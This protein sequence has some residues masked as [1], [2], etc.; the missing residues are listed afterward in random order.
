MSKNIAV[1]MGGFSSEYGI[2]LKSGAVVEKHLDKS[3]FKTFPIVVTSD[4][5]YFQDSSGIQYEV[6]KAD[7]SL[8][9]PE[10]KVVFDCV[11]NAIHGTPRSSK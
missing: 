7:F 5:W 11:F 3:K 8:A 2:S 1:I 10:G 6:D 4:S 9:L